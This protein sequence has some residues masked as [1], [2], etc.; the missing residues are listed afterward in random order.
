MYIIQMADLHIGSENKCLEKENIMLS[1]GIEQIRKHIPKN[2]KIVVCIC[3]DIIDSK[4]SAKWKKETA[5]IRY[6]EAAELFRMMLNK[7]KNEYDIKF[8]FCLGNHDITHINEFL[9]FSKEFDKDITKEKLEDGYY[10]ECEGV[11]YI[12]LN[13]CNGGQYEYGCINY[14]KLE[15]L[16][17][18]I[19][20]DRS[21]IIILHHTV[22]SMY[23]KDPS[24][25]RNSAQL[26][27]FIN[28]NNVFGVLYGHIHGRECFPI[29]Q[30]HCKMIGTGALFSRKYPNVNSQFNIM[31]VKPFIFRE[32]STYIYM[33]DDRIS[34]NPWNKISTEK[35]NDENY[36]QGNN[37]QNV[38]QK[39]LNKLAYEPVLNNVV[40]HL[41][42]FYEEFKNNLEEF[43]QE[44]ELVIGDKH[45]SYFKLAELWEKIQVPECLYFN[46]GMYFKVRD[47]ENDNT[48]VHGIQFIA[49][50]LKAK[51]TSNKAV[52][53]TYGMETVTKMLKGEEYLP[54][55]LSIQFSQSSNGETLYVHMYLRALE[56]GR[57]LK[58]NICEIKWLI[59]CL[60]ERNVLFN[61]VDIAISAFRVQKREKFN[62]FLKA[63]IDTIDDTDLA[64]YISEGNIQKICQMLEEK[65][66]AFETIT[67]VRG[68]EILCKTMKKSN[69]HTKSY[70][71]NSE[72]IDKLDK[73]LS[74]YSKLD[75]IHRR[76]SIKTKEETLYETEIINGINDIIKEFRKE[77]ENLHYDFK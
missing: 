55:L 45:F 56:A 3:G 15:K 25:I 23:E 49:Q 26:I 70:K 59:E 41:N 11:F 65:I 37:F 66:D 74:V 33:A 22:I 5:K 10:M 63:D 77:G 2:Q 4:N 54:S 50:Q 34:G 44:E 19:P 48:E 62:C 47:V 14:E 27:K 1:R 18:E 42:C 13:S 52:L 17:N 60:K 20:K 35:A 71:Y 75:T 57:F 6:D 43:L 28:K 12:F 36:F 40:L 9:N 8:R 58:I 61:K 21:K 24:P 76:G 73:V 7:L 72:T 68:L 16:L 31:E 64:L 38:Y 51:P 69:E 30:K 46:H 32:I 29:G 53:T 39:L 67:N